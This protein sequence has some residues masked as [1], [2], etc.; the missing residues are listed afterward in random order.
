LKTL[1]IL[2]FSAVLTASAQSPGIQS[3]GIQSLPRLE[4][5]PTTSHYRF[6]VDDKPF[7]MLGA[8]INNSSSWPSTLPAAWKSLED[9]HAN[10]AE[11]PVYW[12]Q[13]E[14]TPN[15]FNFASVDLLI[16]QAREHHMRLVLLWFGT[17][18]N[19][20]NHY[21]PEWVKSDTARYPRAIT[22]QGKLLDVMSPLGEATLAADAH[23]FAALM[24]HV[25]EID[26]QHTVILIQVENESGTV[27]AVRDFSATATK[28]FNAQ[29]P[30]KLTS[31][32]HLK[33]G[34][35]S[36]VFG[37]AADE[38][39][40][41][42]TTAH[43]INQVAAAGKA[44][45]A[46]PMYCNVWITY[47]AHGLENRDNPNLTAGQ[48][49][50][51]GGPQQQN[52]PIW[53]AAAPSI[54]ALAPDFYSAETPLFRDVLA[55]YARP[56]NP[57][58]IPETPL[59]PNLGRFF[60]YTLGSGGIGFAPFGIDKAADPFAGDQ[61]AQSA[62]TTKAS[63]NLAENFALLS[64]IGEQIA[65]INYEGKLQTA[66][67]ERGT[68]RQVLHFNGV[69]AIASFGFPQ[70]DGRLPPGTATHTGRA[71]IAQLG[72]QEFLVTGFE[73]SVTFRLPDSLGS[74]KNQQLEILTAEEGTYVN[75]TWAPNRILNGDQ[76][77]RGLNF[78]PGNHT[79]A[80]IRLH[81][82]PLYNQ[83][84]K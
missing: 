52:I 57:L 44:E 28:A 61:T 35:W 64:P 6:L 59:G 74:A 18:K 1:I 54:D 68:E 31:A 58:F 37:P 49:Y 30:A 34:T 63:A 75:G 36:Q 81:T 16:T 11:A 22:A 15:A 65:Q 43:Y 14:P 33:P 41:A 47:P 26:P 4:K 66:V 56:D 83:P 7:L 24:H 45:L 12:E 10:T 23:A 80:R 62:A 25:K 76:T 71:L 29:V 21:V 5:N 39:F 70:G 50:P 84:T 79:I 60:F 40:A 42:Y 38:S 19:G 17:W 77:D 9:F 55:A 78:Y 53:K 3:P 27:G 13:L 69:D 2:L 51:S 72:P 32:L 8:Q 46:L 20:Q 67:E 48:D 73:A 82:L